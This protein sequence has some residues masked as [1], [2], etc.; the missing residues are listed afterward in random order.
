MPGSRRTLTALFVLALVIT[1]AGRSIPAAG[2]ASAVG[3]GS[4]ITASTTLKADVGPCPGNGL[5]VRASH[6]VLDLG[7]HHVLGT[8]SQKGPFP[9]TNKSDGV[10]V[11]LAGVKDV[12]VTNG[13]V[14]HFAAGVRL[15][16]GSGNTVSHLDVHDNIGLRSDADNGDGIALFGSNHNLVQ[17]NIV[18]HNGV[19]D[20]ITML[21]SDGAT[22]TDGSSFNTVVNNRLLDNDLA[23]LDSQGAPTWKRDIGIAIEGPGSTHNLVDHNV[24][25]G[26]GTDGVQVFPDCINSY[27]IAKGCAG[28]VPNDYNVISNNVVNHNGFGA[29]VATAPLGDGIIV[30]SMGPKVVVKPGHT[31]IAN[32]ITNGNQ[33]NGIAIGG[34]NGEDLFNSPGTTGGGNYGCSNINSDGGSTGDPT[35][36]LCGSSHDTVTNNSSAG[37]GEDGI[38][39]G[40]T[41]D[42][43]LVTDNKV[44]NNTK[45]GIAVGRAVKYGKDDKAVFDSQGRPVTIP[46]TAGTDNTI[47]LNR[48]T[49]NG[50][51]DGRDDNRGC[52]NTWEENHFITVNQACVRGFFDPTAPAAPTP[53]G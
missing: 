49:G 43:N 39:I 31:T 40:P 21:S 37:N 18:R 23:M 5:V 42:F 32:N 50:R 28:T 8:F 6:L 26:S 25:T 29:P 10:G 36:A 27:D 2:A 24:I 16:G 13:A 33:R 47:M 51:W 35:A 11:D 9:P 30:L 14:S 41:S 48:A 4:V 34:G 15:R 53:T 12:T 1:G 20:G 22:G 38:W 52:A 46:G 44:T 7:G 3:C 19:W 45:D 17:D